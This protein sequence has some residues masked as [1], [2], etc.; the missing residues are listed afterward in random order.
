MK[1]ASKLSKTFE[2]IDTDVM[3]LVDLM[4]LLL[5]P[6]TDPSSSSLVGMGF[7]SGTLYFSSSCLLMK[8]SNSFNFF[9]SYVSGFGG[10]STGVTVIVGYW[11]CFV[12]FF[13]YSTKNSSVVWH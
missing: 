12:A 2:L 8:S 7:S 3:L 13:R 5:V 4:M 10:D 6:I 11:R 1:L 9:S